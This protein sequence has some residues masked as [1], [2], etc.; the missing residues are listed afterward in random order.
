MGVRWWV[1]GG[2]WCFTG[3]GEILAVGE[4][5]PYPFKWTEEETAQP[6]MA[7]QDLQEKD[8]KGSQFDIDEPE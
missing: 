3:Y 5:A 7:Q 1:L 8:G 6:K 2:G 4:H